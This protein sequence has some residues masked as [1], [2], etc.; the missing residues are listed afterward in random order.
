MKRSLGFLALLLAAAVLTGCASSYPTGML[1]T[2][3]KLPVLATGAPSGALK[4]GTAECTSIL[5]LVATGDASINTA[6][7]NGNITKVHHVDWDVEN[8]LGI[9][10][11]YKCTVYGE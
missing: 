2:Q 4:V 3:L 1:Y 10:G 7:K 6:M 8:I 11:K 9:I 5:A